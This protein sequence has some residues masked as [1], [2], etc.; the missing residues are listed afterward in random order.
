[1]PVK[2]IELSFKKGE[3]VT[4]NISFDTN[5]EFIKR[6]HNLFAVK[7]GSIIYSL[8]VKFKEEMLEYETNGVERKF[9]YCDYELIPQSDWNY[10]FKNKKLTLVKNQVNEIPFSSKNPPCEIK[11]NMQKIDWGFEPGYDTVCDK[12]PRSTKAISKTEELSLYPYGCAKL[13]VTE[14]PFVK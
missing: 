1:M 3:E 9:P 11:V 5:P 14:L 2:D 4:L 10:G 13:R 12:I 6:P 7:N 8:P